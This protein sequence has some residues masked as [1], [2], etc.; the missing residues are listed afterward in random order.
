MALGGWH[1]LIENGCIEYIDAEEE[2][3]TMISMMIN[4]SRGANFET[5]LF[6]L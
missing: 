4:V 2:E 3:T 6:G 1:D 5:G